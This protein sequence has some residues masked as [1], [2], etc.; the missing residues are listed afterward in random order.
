GRQGSDSAIG[1]DDLCSGHYH[2]IVNSSLLYEIVHRLRFVVLGN[3]DNL[4]TVLVLF[5]KLDQFRNLAAAGGTP[6]GPEV[7]KHDFAFQVLHRRDLAGEIL[8]LETWSRFGIADKTN[9]RR[10]GSSLRG[11]WCRGRSRAP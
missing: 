6:G 7:H 5:L 8:N 3:A 10:S 9:H 2:R 11:F 1:L 4:Q